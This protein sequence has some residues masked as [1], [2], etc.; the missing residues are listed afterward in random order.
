[1]LGVTLENDPQSS[2]RAIAFEQSLEKLGWTVGRNLQIDY[3]WGASDNEEARAAAEQLMGLG[4]ELVVANSPPPAVRGVQQ[5]FP[6]V[7]IIFVAVSEPMAL[8]LVASMAKPG[9]NATGFTNLEPSVAG[10]WVELLKEIAPRVKRAAFMFNPETAPLIAP[11][12]LPVAEAAASKFGVELIV[13]HVRTPADI[14]AAITKH[15]RELGGGLIVPPD[16][17]TTANHKLVVEVAARNQLPAIAAFQY[18]AAAG[19]LISYGP[20][21]VDQFR[22]AASYVDRILRGEKPGDLPVQQPTKFEL[23]LNLK[24]AKALD[25]D[26]PLQLQQIADEVIE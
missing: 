21:V 4:S 16:T 2:R 19:A 15:G 3:R 1:M 24:T 22:R 5:V 7:P 14:D 9:G 17:F 23:I 12:F 10:K 25:L 18:F 8:G 11:L 20:D 26:V 13:V 6:T